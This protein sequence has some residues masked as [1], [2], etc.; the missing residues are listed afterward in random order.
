MGSSSPHL[1]TLSS[2]HPLDTK[3]L[4]TFR[5]TAGNG[6]VA[7]LAELID[8]YLEESPKQLQ[9][10]EA[11]IAQGDASTLRQIAHRFKSSSASLGATN[12]ASLCKELEIM[13]ST[14]VIEVEA[15]KVSQ[16]GAEYERVKAALQVE[17]QAFQA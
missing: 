16:L 10:M 1:L 6:A 2:P 7:F 3:V 12:L 5:A 15:E 9:A 17:K 4:Q 13:N 14:E 8:C 11:A